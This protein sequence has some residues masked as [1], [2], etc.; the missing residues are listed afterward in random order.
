MQLSDKNR[1]LMFRTAG[2]V[3]GGQMPDPIPVTREELNG[4]L[5]AARA[6]G[7]LEG[8]AEQRS[9]CECA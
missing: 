1:S 8:R 2:W 3:P 6:E 7:R 5:D 4:L 9:A